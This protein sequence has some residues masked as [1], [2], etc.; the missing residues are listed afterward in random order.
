LLTT[1]APNWDQFGVPTMMTVSGSM[2]RMRGM[3]S[4]A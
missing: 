1:S 3:I 4:L 2:A